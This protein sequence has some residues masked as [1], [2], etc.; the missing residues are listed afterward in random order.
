MKKITLLFISL[1]AMAAAYAQ[2]PR[3]VIVEHFTNTDC[4]ICAGKNPTFFA[5]LRSFPEV[6]HIA[7][8]PDQP[9]P[10][11]LLSHENRSENVARTQFYGV[12]GGTPRAVIQGVVIATKTPT[13]DSLDIDTMLRKYSPLD[14]RLKMIKV[15]SDS[16]EVRATILTTGLVNYPKLS[17]LINV[18]EDTIFY[19][20]GNGEHLHFDV[21]HKQ[22]LPG[23]GLR[24]T[25][26]STIGDSLVISSGFRISQVDSIWN[27]SRIN[28][29][30]MIQDSATKFIVQAAKQTKI[31]TIAAVATGIESIQA[32]E[33][34]SFHPNPASDEITFSN[35]V[36]KHLVIYDLTGKIIVEENIVTDHLSISGIASGL[37]Y[38][39]CINEQAK[40]H[41][42]C[43]SVM[44]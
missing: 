27:P 21:F 36:P 29:I 44:H 3:T 16:I 4:S 41:V 42:M 25:P 43:L 9:H 30:G 8:H 5:T 6:I 17:I 20:G 39:A 31:D 34:F 28:I 19:T 18:T 26:S 1:M 7:Y 14:L 38:V 35:S 10:T 2:T 12:Y 40:T 13:I 24:I 37:Y 15:N 11:C 33:D 22:L 23:S 32:T